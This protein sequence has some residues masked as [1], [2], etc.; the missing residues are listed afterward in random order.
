MKSLDKDSSTKPP[1]ILAIHHAVAALFL[2]VALVSTAMAENRCPALKGEN[3][4][5]AKLKT[6]AK[7]DKVKENKAAE[8]GGTK[9]SVL[10]A[11]AVA[12]S[13]KS[14][15]ATTQLARVI[16]PMDVLPDIID[17]KETVPAMG[18]DLTASLPVE[19]ATFLDYFRHQLLTRKGG[20]LNLYTSYTGR[21]PCRGSGELLNFRLAE[22]DRVYFNRDTPGEQKAL[23]FWSHGLGGR[24]LKTE[25]PGTKT[26]GMFTAYFG[27][28]MD[29]PLFTDVV[30]TKSPPGVFSFEIYYSYNKLNKKTLKEAFALSDEPT[31]FRTYGIN[32]RF[33]LPGSYQIKVEHLKGVGS[34]A[35][36]RLGDLTL[37]SVAYKKPD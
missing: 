11:L 7:E 3:E 36:E 4:S 28:G 33:N 22:T 16:T 2:G 17:P 23:F 35:K 18:F 8:D 21:N 13:G 27:V 5:D 25:L 14:M 15:L 10:D 12:G 24:A 30:D 26:A 19:N 32:F 6:E 31:S 29:G 20:L 9:A 34:F 1:Q 37:L